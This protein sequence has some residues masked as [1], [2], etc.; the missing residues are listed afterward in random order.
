MLLEWCH[1]NKSI[2]IMYRSSPL[3]CVLRRSDPKILTERA[4]RECDH[5]HQTHPGQLR[6]RLV[7][8][9]GRVVLS[10]PLCAADSYPAPVK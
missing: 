9:P 6:T 10:V 2:T 4:R 5:S 1:R 7:A 8:P 3:L